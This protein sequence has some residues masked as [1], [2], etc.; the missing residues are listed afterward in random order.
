[1]NFLKISPTLLAVCLMLTLT[2]C[3][4]RREVERLGIVTGM[5]VETAPGGRVR[6][7]VQN[8]NPAGL[9]KGA[10]GA[11]GVGAAGA[12]TKPYRNRSAEGD[13]VFDAIRKL[14]LQSPRRLFFAHTQVLV[15]SEQ[16][17]RERGVREILDFLERNPEIRLRTWILIGKGDLATLLD[18]PGRLDPAPSLR[19]FDILSERELTSKYAVQMLRPFLEQLQG[20]CS[21]TFTALVDR[22]PNLAFSPEHAQRTPEAH[23]AEPHHNIVLNGTAVF[24]QDKMAGWLN[25]RESRGLLWVRGKVAGGIIDVPAPEGAGKAVTLEILRSKTK[26]TPGIRDGQIFMTV[27]IKVESNLA[28]AAAPL[29]LTRPEVIEKLEAAEAGAIMNEVES[30]LTKA[31][32][33]YGV[34]VFGFGRAVHNKYPE[35]WK[36]IKDGWQEIFPTVPVEMQVEAKIRRTGLVSG[37]IEPGKH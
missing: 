16:L 7:V 10:G 1:M 14:S 23:I 6:V 30:A 8:I 36:E 18:E 25:D 24:R 3:W 31:Q 35:D 26:L 9:G 4:D 5:G 21:Y 15:I 27:D 32:H 22:E 11:G 28:E 37:P 34:D 12:A 20:E 2:A 19:I 33:E 17:A 13:T 29:D